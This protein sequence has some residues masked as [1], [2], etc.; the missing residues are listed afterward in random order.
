M[1][2]KN[3]WATNRRITWSVMDRWLSCRRRW[4]YR[5]IGQFAPPAGLALL[6]G[7][8]MHSLFEAEGRLNKHVQSGGWGASDAE[9]H[10]RKKDI[11]GYIEQRLLELDGLFALF[12]EEALKPLAAHNPRDITS[13]TPSYSEEDVYAESV[14]MQRVFANWLRLRAADDLLNYRVLWVEKLIDDIHLP[15]PQGGNARGWRLAG[16]ID[17]LLQ[18][19][20]NGQIVLRELKT[21]SGDATAYEKRVDIDPQVRLY[22]QA[23]YLSGIVDR[24]VETVQYVVLRKKVPSLPQDVQ[25]KSCKGTGKTKKTK[26]DQH[27]EECGVCAGSGSIPS[28]DKRLDSTRDVLLQYLQRKGLADTVQINADWQHVQLYPG[29]WFV[30]P[31]YAELARNMAGWEKFI[32]VN[33]YWLDPE[34]KLEAIAEAWRVSQ[35]I[36]DATRR[37][38][39]NKESYITAFPRNIEK[40][41]GPTGFCEYKQMCIARQTVENFAGGLGWASKLPD[42]PEIVALLAQGKD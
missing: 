16:I 21:T 42:N 30:D 24:P 1:E 7:T 13:V 11:E 41:T 15:K 20:N 10:N 17:A 2:L 3:S 38:A 25:C 29:L 6:A 27:Q 28:A 37:Y 26:E 8:L 40:C 5:Y 18:D 4:Y 36:S 12:R 14:L 23:A 39:R 34:D 9:A 33:T 35:E 32:S 31:R 22:A 19:R